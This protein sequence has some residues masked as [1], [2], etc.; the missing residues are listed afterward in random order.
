[1]SQGTWGR[2]S[3]CPYVFVSEDRMRTVGKDENEIAPECITQVIPTPVIVLMQKKPHF[4]LH[5]SVST[6]KSKQIGYLGLKKVSRAFIQKQNL[7]INQ[8]GF[9]CIFQEGRT[10]KKLASLIACIFPIK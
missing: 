5:R 7:A 9:G 6:D 4:F 8:P 3:S 2:G 10:E 1:M